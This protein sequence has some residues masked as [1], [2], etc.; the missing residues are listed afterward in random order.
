MNK[1]YITLKNIENLNQNTLNKNNDVCKTQ[2]RYFF[3][4]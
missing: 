4:V 1:Q 3:K 2:M